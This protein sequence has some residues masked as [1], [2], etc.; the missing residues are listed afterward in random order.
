MTHPVLTLHVQG[1]GSHF[2]VG[3]ATRHPAEFFATLDTLPR[4]DG[5]THYLVTLRGSGLPKLMADGVEAIEA[6]VKLG[7]IVARHLEQLDDE[8]R[9]K[10]EGA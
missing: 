6:A 5:L 3:V 10:T 2:T 4:E 9:K 8:F 1:L 7:Y